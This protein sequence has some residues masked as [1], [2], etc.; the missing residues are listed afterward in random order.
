[1]KS[2]EDT[3]ILKEGL[4]EAKE[5]AAEAKEQARKNNQSTEGLISTGIPGLFRVKLG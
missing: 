3:K 1:M 5:A 2:E 4:K